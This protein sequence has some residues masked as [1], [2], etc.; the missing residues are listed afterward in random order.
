MF[1][2]YFATKNQEVVADV[3]CVSDFFVEDLKG[4]A[5]LTTESILKASPF[6]VYKFKPNSMPD[7]SQQKEFVRANKDKI[8]VIGNFS[9]MQPQALEE[10]RRQGSRYFII[11]Y[12][13]K[14]CAFRSPQ[15]HMTQTGKPCDCNT[16]AIGR[17]MGEFFSGAKHIFFMSQAQRAWYHARFPALA[18]KT[19]VQSSTWDAEQIDRLSEFRSVPKNDKW[20]ILGSTSWIKGTKQ[21]IEFAQKMNLPFDVVGNMEYDAFVEKLAQYHGL[22]FMPLGFDTCPRIVVE[23]NLMGLKA[24]TN[25][26]VQHI[27]EPWSQLPPEELVEVLKKRPQA[28]WDKLKSFL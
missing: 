19:S 25:S 28:F 9:S 8:W 16:Q 10:L 7:L 18:D 12:D 23:A 20:A 26:M 2:D 24:M 22:L 27:S 6:S 1:T 14:Y 17:W 3:I 11:E 5:E 13:Y 15:L 4:G 21:T